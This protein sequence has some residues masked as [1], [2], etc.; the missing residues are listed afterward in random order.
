MRRSFLLAV[1]LVLLS[2]CAGGGE[3]A[4]ADP[5]KP[6]SVD[7]ATSATNA[8][9]WLV[10]E[11][12]GDFETHGVTIGKL[13]LGDGGSSTLR[14]ALAGGAPVVEVSF[15]AAVEAIDQ[16][17]EIE[18]VSGSLNT[19][20]GVDF[21]ALADNSAVQS[22]EDAKTLGVTSPGSISET[23][24]T[25]ALEQLG[26]P[27]P[28]FVQTGGIGE[29]VALLESGDV[30]A[31]FITPPVAASLGDKIREIFRASDELGSVQ[32]SVI[33][34]ST[35]YATTHPKAVQAIVAALP[36]AAEQISSDPEGAT[37][38]WAPKLDLEPA[39]LMPYIDRINQTADVWQIG[40]NTDALN[41]AVDA[42]A[43]TGY[44]GEVDFCEILTDK[45]LPEG[46]PRGPLEEC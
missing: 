17:A 14:S 31:T 16:G 27:K 10:A 9:P 5:D 35:E 43:L 32:T 26:V 37:E 18:I 23:V 40:F 22:V 2:A 21:Y 24:T 7:F 25:L 8:L 36:D 33:V 45:Y 1:P 38:I 13:D 39:A 46:A 29:G 44:E 28:K 34:A 42:L 12:N 11:E 6:I 20:V 15:A 3:A 30:D 19:A 4:D 41:R